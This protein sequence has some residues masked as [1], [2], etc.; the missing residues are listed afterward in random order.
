MHPASII[1]MA[2]LGV[3]GLA[4][5]GLL[6]GSFYTVDEG[7]RAVVVSQGKVSGVSGPGFHWKAPFITD[8]HI[9]SV[10]TQ[11]IEFPE[12]PVYTADRQTANVT[13]SVNYAAS[14]RPSRASRGVR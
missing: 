14:I 10:R 11:A 3:I 2:F 13:F 1:K 12:E 8:A 4:V 7:E 9:I 6:G 5:V